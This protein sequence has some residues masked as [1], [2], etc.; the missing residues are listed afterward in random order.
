[1]NVARRRLRTCLALCLVIGTLAVG[2]SQAG[3]FSRRSSRKAAAPVVRRSLIVFPFD[4]GGV[5]KA[6]EGFGVYVAG[7][8]RAMLAANEA[9][10]PLVYRERLSPVQRAIDDN[11]LKNPDIIGPFAEDKAKTLKLARL[12]A[13]DLFLVGSV[14]DCVVDGTKKMGEVTLSASLYETKTGKLLKTFLVSART[15][16]GTKTSEEDELRD[17]AKGAAVTK[18]VAELVAVPKVEEDAPAETPAK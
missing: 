16:E 8:V 15:P 9:I 17:V 18:L 5:A 10:M 11:T 7:D 4:Q 14:D 2:S 3:L 1:M 12:L 13:S 6:P